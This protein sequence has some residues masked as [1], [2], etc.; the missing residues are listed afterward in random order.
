MTRDDLIQFSPAGHSG[1]AGACR[2]THWRDG[3]WRRDIVVLAV[4]PSGTYKVDGLAR[5]HLT[6]AVEAQGLQLDSTK[7]YTVEP[8]T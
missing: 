4:F 5:A 1:R 2:V 6:N 7:P 8:L 3:A